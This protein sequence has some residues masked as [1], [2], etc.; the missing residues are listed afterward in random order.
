MVFQAIVV[1]IISLIQLRNE[2]GIRSSDATSYHLSPPSNDQALL[3]NPLTRSEPAVAP[4]PKILALPNLLPNFLSHSP[5]CQDAISC[6][7]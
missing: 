1:G 6:L 5:C 4:A 7:S 3:I 2:I